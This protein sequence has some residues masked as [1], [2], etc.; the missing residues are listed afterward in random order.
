MSHFSLAQNLDMELCGRNWWA[1]VLLKAVWW[2]MCLASLL[3]QL[4]FFCT[5]GCIVYVSLLYLSLV[6]DFAAVMAK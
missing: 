4:F 5:T 6:C 1:A 3:M 2:G